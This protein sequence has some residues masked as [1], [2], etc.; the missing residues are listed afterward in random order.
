MTTRVPPSPMEDRE[1]YPL[2]EE[3]DVTEIPRH[4][5]QVRYLR[6]ALSARFPNWFV[7]GNVGIYW[8]KGNYEL[9]RAPDVFVVREPLPVPDPR[10][11]L[12]FEDPSIVFVAE[13]GSR[14]TQR[15]DEGP[16]LEIY[17][18]DI[19][20]AEYLYADPP[21]RDVR[22][23]RL[24]PQGSEAVAPEGAPPRSGGPG[25]F[26]SLELDVEFGLDE[27]GFLRIY[28]LEG[29]R[30]LTHEET[31]QHL[32]DT[33]Q[34]L[35]DTR[36]RLQEAEARAADEGARRQEPERRLAELQARLG[37]ASGAPRDAEPLE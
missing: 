27:D 2:H 4:E 24:G 15:A 20:A 16:K 3:D 36:Q 28:T 12:T 11:Y 26:R 22:F 17:A 35:Q 21:R 7:T 19:H 34:H 18:R 6:D 14:S 5:R 30:L 32:Q 33:Q 8:E 9:Y 23:W 1:L 25:R 13:I 29:E 37:E 10:V 31:D